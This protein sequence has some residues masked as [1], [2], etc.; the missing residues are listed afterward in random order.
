MAAMAVSLMLLLASASALPN[1]SGHRR[2]Q[3]APSCSGN[4]DG[5][6]DVDVADLINV[7]RLSSGHSN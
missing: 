7:Q 4:F 1:S 3:D 5:D 6:T 2:L